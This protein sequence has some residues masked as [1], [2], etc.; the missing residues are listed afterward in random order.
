[1]KRLGTTMKM[2]LKP[3][4]VYLAVAVTLI[5]GWFYWSEYRPMKIRIACSEYALEKAMDQWVRH[6]GSNPDRSYSG[7]VRQD[8]YSFCLDEAGLER[9]HS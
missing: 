8:Y 3:T 7:D 1:M 2:K 5:L 9:H 4:Y 6:Y